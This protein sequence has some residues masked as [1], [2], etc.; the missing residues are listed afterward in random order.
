M[1]LRTIIIDDEPFVRNDLLRMLSAFQE[2]EVASQA[3]SLSEAREQLTADRYD[4]VF[5][6]VCLPGGSGFDLLPY[7][8]ASSRVVFVTGHGEY[9]VEAF[10]INALDYLL[11]PVSPERL[12]NTIRRL[13][14]DTIPSFDSA[15]PG[16]RISVK[17]DAGHLYLDPATIVAVSSL[18]GN[19]ME[20]HLDGRDRVLCRKTL[21]EWEEKLDGVLVRIH[22]STLINPAF[23]RRVEKGPADKNRTDKNRGGGFRVCMGGGLIFQVSR[24][25]APC[26][27]RQLSRRE[28][29]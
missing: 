28:R 17:T 26:L 19:Y 12:S 4:L 20:V 5:L 25:L 1:S 2:V 11:K 14:S 18:G 21:K 29:S 16:E 13:A 23:V 24:R 9:A 6:D 7:I 10:E 3:S 15:P 27:R 22:R 8:E